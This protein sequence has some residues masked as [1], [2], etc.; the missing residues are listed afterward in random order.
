MPSPATKIPKT[1]EMFP[2][3]KPLQ[4]PN[5]ENFADGRMVW[6]D[7]KKLLDFLPALDHDTEKACFMGIPDAIAELYSSEMTHHV[8]LPR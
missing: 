5:F 8:P 6:P 3:P 7:Q 1:S 2:T 4:F